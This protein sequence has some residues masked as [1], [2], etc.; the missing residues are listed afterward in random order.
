MGDNHRLPDWFIACNTIFEAD[1][2]NIIPKVEIVPS[3]TEKNEAQHTHGGVHHDPAKIPDNAPSCQIS[4]HDFSLLRDTTAA[5]FTRSFSGVL[6]RMRSVVTLHTTTTGPEHFLDDVVKLL[7]KDMRTSLISFG[8]EDLEDM[9]TEFSNQTPEDSSGSSSSNSKEWKPCS[10][11]YWFTSSSD[12]K[13]NPEAS[14]RCQK[15]FSTLLDAIPSRQLD[16]NGGTTD[17]T[18]EEQATSDSYVLVHVREAPRMLV[19]DKGHRFLSRLDHCVQQR[20]QNGQNIALIVTIR[21]LDGRNHDCSCPDCEE[22]CFNWKLF[23]NNTS[24]TEFSTVTIN[25]VNID[26]VLCHTHVD[27]INSVN[28]RRMK[29][30]L[31]INFY[32]LFAPEILRPDSDW[33]QLLCNKHD[34]CFAQALWPWEDICRAGI[35]ISGRSWGR[36]HIEPRDIL[37][38]LSRLGLHRHVEPA[39]PSEKEPQNLV[40]ESN[41]PESVHE[42]TQQTWEQKL[43]ALRYDCNSHETSL[44]PNVVDPDKIRSSYSQV[45]INEELKETVLHL[46]S[47]SYLG[48]ATTSGSLL[49]QFRLRGI[50]L[51]GPPGTGKT[52]LTRA[53]AKESGAAMLSVDTASLVSKYVGETEKFISAAF[54]LASKLSPCVLFIDEADALFYDR[55]TARRS[56]ERSAVTQFL[57]EMDGLVDN[58]NAPCVVVATNRPD[59]LDS[60]FLRRLP[61]KIPVG[62]PDLEA[63]FKI[64]ELFLEGEELEPL[65]DIGSLAREADGYSG[66]DLRS[67]CAEAAL[68]WAIDQSKKSRVN[69]SSHAPEKMR[70]GPLHFARAFQK[71]RPSVSKAD[72]DDLA[73]FTKR[74][75]PNAIE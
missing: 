22:W 14:E 41:L 56:W 20:R 26:Q 38:V 23:Y 33:G 40:A 25:P 62:L 37:L 35:Q 1:L 17:G 43:D 72:V 32:H 21:S 39:E 45:I 54:S 65:V 52:H 7:A 6:G 75:N 53:I 13:A 19:A 16:V 49:S 5:A 29:R 71:I 50:M 42:E 61:Q 60:A 57:T 9:G 11:K 63:R 34:Q 15:S 24:A 67:L 73:E 44:L 69:G 58:A 47:S 66:S 51:Y 55:K 70:L 12:E 36:G 68:L 27:T 31:G 3:S 59:I 30:V 48:P 28:T 64:L 2:D 18:Q 10:A 8:L 74:F 46:V 4:S